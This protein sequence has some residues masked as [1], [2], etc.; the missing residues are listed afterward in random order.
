MTQFNCSCDAPWPRETMQTLRVR[1]MRRLGFSAQAA[2][3]PPGM[4]ELLRDF[5][6]E[7]QRLVYRDYNCFRQA[8]I[9]RWLMTVGERFYDFADDYDSIIQPPALSTLTGTPEL[10]GGVLTK[11]IHEFKFTYTNAQGETTGSEIFEVETFGVLDTSR[12]V[13][14]WTLPT[15][16]DCL[17]P[18]TAVNIYVRSPDD[19]VTWV[20][21]YTELVAG[22]DF[23]YNYTGVVGPIGLSPY[24]EIPATNGT[25]SVAADRFV[26]DPF[27]IQWVATSRTDAGRFYPLTRGI[28]AHHLSDPIESGEPCRWDIRNCL[29][30]WPA[31][32]V[33][34]Y[35]YLKTEIGLFPFAVDAD[36]TTL[37]PD[38]IFLRALTNAKAHY[39]HPDAGN[40]HEQEMN[41]IGRIVSA[42][43][44]GH[45]YVPMNAMRP[46][47][48]ERPVPYENFEA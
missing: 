47:Q 10:T 36:Y 35:L 21:Q 27:K 5:L 16:D 3:P 4:S 1:L 42:S 15:I 14:S 45:R 7:A 28:P 13:L 46:S 2:S 48:Y 34:D 24:T 33:A 41:L 23:A 37:D 11:K 30:V 26:M 25:A 29:E 17:S 12:I 20:L 40:Y 9:F 31:P 18:I 39:K 6:S 8:R 38:V 22:S 19:D 43:H 44:A 32:T